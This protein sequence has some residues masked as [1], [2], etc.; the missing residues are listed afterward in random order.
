MNLYRI[1]YNSYT[2][3]L[4][5]IVALQIYEQLERVLITLFSVFNKSRIKPSTNTLLI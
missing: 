2:A 3:L 4:L 1:V 5:F